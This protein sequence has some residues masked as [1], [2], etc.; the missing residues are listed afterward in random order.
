MCDTGLPVPDMVTVVKPDDAVLE[1]WFM[2]GTVTPG[3]GWRGSTEDRSLLVTLVTAA[4]LFSE[5]VPSL[6]FV[7]GPEGCTTWCFYKTKTRKQS[8]FC[9]LKCAMFRLHIHALTVHYRVKQWNAKQGIK[10][11]F[12]QLNLKR[13]WFQCD[14]L[15]H[16]RRKCLSQWWWG[17]CLVVV[18]CTQGWGWNA[19]WLKA[20]GRFLLISGEGWFAGNGV[21]SRIY[22]RKGDWLCCDWLLKWNNTNREHHFTQLIK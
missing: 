5:L 2:I 11:K 6:S 17:S 12:T 1:A 9:N 22:L 21:L 13:S 8:T 14:I 15:L 20:G 10:L 16:C 3:G 7:A 4:E 19:G 18:C